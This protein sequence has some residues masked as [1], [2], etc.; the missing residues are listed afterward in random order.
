M[1][2]L[3]MSGQEGEVRSVGRALDILSL[4]DGPHPTRHLRE[5]VEGTELPKTTVV[6]LLATLVQRQLVV[7]QSEGLYTLGA[8]FLRWVNVAT[9]GW[10]V[11]DGVMAEMRRLSDA[12]GETCNLY[13]RQGCYRVVI[14]QHE[15]NRSVRN[16]VP[17]GARLPLWAGASGKILLAASPQMVE[18][19][20]AMANMGPESRDLLRRSVASAGELNHAVT[21]GER[22]FGASGVA[23]GVR[24]SKGNVIA[25]L[26]L[27][28]PTSRF[29]AE[30]IDAFLK[31]TTKSAE[32]VSRIGMPGIELLV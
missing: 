31:E 13:V 3:P 2:E 8:G 7:Q 16:V 27:G 9:A 17:L 22:E 30:N 25:A 6:R 29:G 18:E 21:H 28:G 4:F 14:A 26:A 11:P 24:G 20:A 1:S 10:K 15:P 5:L 23:V 32:A 12:V 19:A